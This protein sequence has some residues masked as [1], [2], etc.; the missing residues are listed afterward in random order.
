M[1][2]GEDVRRRQAH[3]A[4]PRAVGA[5]ADRGPHR[6]DSL[7][8]DRLLGGVD[9]LRHRLEVGA[10]VA[11][12]ALDVDLDLRARG[13]RRA[14]LAAVRSNSSTCSAQLL[15]VEVA[16]DRADLGLAARPG[17]RV[18]W[19][20]PS[21]PDVV[22]GVRR[23]DGSAATIWAASRS[24]LTSLPVAWPGWTSTPRTVTVD[25]ERRE[26]LVLELA[27][28]R[29]V[30]R[31]GARGAEPLDVEQRRPLADLLVGRER[32]P[33]RRPR[34]LRVRGQVGDR[35]HDL[36]DAGLVVG[37]E[38]RVAAGGD[39]VVAALV[40]QLRHRRRIEPGAVARQLDHAAVVVAVDDRLDARARA[41]RESCPCGRSARSRA[42]RPRCP[43]SVAV[44]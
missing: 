7:G 16:H 42:R 43:G 18:G 3:L 10:H 5:A 13:A 32:D 14:P 37:T 27:E 22:S 38:Q 15:L 35:G 40:E 29:A 21:R 34:Q 33:Q 4:Q 11:V 23:S 41:R 25:L 6:L 44:T 9:D 1:A 8:A 30:E 2:A 24:A 28:L 31:V 19:M 17:Q 12:L 36:G 20:N 26:R 39:D